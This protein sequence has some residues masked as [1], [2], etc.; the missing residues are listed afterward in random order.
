MDRVLLISG[1][2]KGRELFGGLLREQGLDIP[3]DII[4]EDECAAALTK[5]L[6]ERK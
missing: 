2:G 3:A 6:E 1:S 5:I 4:S